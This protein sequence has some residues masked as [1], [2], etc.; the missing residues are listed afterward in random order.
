MF[1]S[2][3]N[4]SRIN[5]SPSAP[6][7]VGHASSAFTLVELLVV[8]GVIAVLIAILLPA[9]GA[10]RRQANLTACLARLQQINVANRLFADRHR[11][12]FPLTGELVG[13][14]FAAPEQLSDSTRQRYA[15]VD[16]GIAATPLRL[17]QWRQA[18]AALVMPQSTGDL[19]DS[20]QSDAAADFF[21][22]PAH[23]DRLRDLDP[24]RSLAWPSTFFT[25]KSSYIVNEAVFGWDDARGRLRG[26]SIRVRNP[27][28]VT[29]FLDGIAS[30]ARAP[31]IS[32]TPGEWLTVFNK[33]AGP[34]ITLAD[35]LAGNA[36]AGDPSNFDLRRHKGKLNISFADG[37]AETRRLDAGDLANVYLL[38]PR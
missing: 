19:N 13:P 5:F 21:R 15:Y 25:T 2:R 9:L 20:S 37:H 8:I 28:Q 14:T 30:D 31:V 32:G 33:T 22:C 36:K 1:M 38:P 29:L 26:N 12:F 35:A 16:T 11:G 18:L 4:D 6:R 23:L 7:R 27:S 34:G 24:G 3:S 17:Q 10:A